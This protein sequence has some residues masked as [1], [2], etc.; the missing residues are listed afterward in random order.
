MAELSPLRQRMIEEMM[1]RNL[2]PETQLLRARGGKIF[3]PPWQIAGSV[4]QGVAASIW[5]SSDHR[6]PCTRDFLGDAVSSGV[7]P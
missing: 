4:C 1:I 3:P 6:F 2:S 5:W 7:Q